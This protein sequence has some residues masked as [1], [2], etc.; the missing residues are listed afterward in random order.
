MKSPSHN[1]DHT[2]SKETYDEAVSDSHENKVHALNES[3]SDQG[4]ARIKP[5]EDKITLTVSIY[6]DTREIQAQF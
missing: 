1:Q 4:S 3:K 5:V 6:K 2:I